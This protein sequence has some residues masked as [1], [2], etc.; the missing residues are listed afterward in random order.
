[1]VVVGRK[2]G[3]KNQISLPAGL[4]SFPRGGGSAIG[5]LAQPLTSAPAAVAHAA[6]RAA[7]SASA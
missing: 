6:R 5:A 1:V 3:K 4:K 2:K 7:A